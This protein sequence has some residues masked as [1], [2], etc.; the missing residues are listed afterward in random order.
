MPHDMPEMTQQFR[1]AELEVAK[2]VTDQKIV[3]IFRYETPGRTSGSPSL[4]LIAEIHS[5]LYAYERLL[6]VLNATAD[7][8]RLLVAQSDQDP[9]GRFEKLVQRLNEAVAN[10]NAQEPTQINWSRISVF[11]IELSDGHLC[12]TGTGQLMN[13]FLQ[14]Q[15]DGSFKGFDLFGSLEQPS[16]TD[17]QKPFGSIICGDI[18]PGDILFVGTTNLERLRN[19]LRMKERLT[20]LPPVTAALELR[21]DIERRG[22][23]DDFIGAVISCLEI[24]QPAAE[25]PMAAHADMPVSRS[26]DS[27]EKLRT[28]ER[29]AEE[30]LSPAIAPIGKIPQSKDIMDL[31]RVTGSKTFHAVRRTV[32][33]L[34]KKTNRDAVALASLRGM[35]AGYGTTFT[36]KKKLILSCIGGAIVLVIAGSLWWSHSKK[37]AAQNAA[38]NATFDSAADLRNRAE[39]DLV[40]GNEARARTEMT[41]AEQALTGLPTDT[42]DRQLKMQKIMKDISDLHER[43]KKVVAVDGVAELYALSVAAAPGSMSAPFI[44]KDAAYTV[45]QNAGE[46]VKVSLTT[47]EAKHIALPHGAGTL[48]SASAGKDSIFF[49]SQD[50]NLYALNTSSDLVKA[51][52]WSHSKASSTR[53]TVLYAN[54]LYSLDPSRNQIWRSVQSGSGFTGETPY[55]KASDASLEGAIGLAIDSNVYVL[56]SNGQLL[57]FLS[58]GQISLNLSSVDPAIRAASGIWTDADAA[59]IYVSDL[60]DKRVL[61]F[62]KNGS[63]KSQ[64][65]SPQFSQL[66]AISVDETN[67]RAVVIDNNRLLLVPLP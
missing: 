16:Q 8:A 61:V 46:I 21:Q 36:K 34:A 2:S 20:T 23:P 4:L 59:S 15:E 42:P 18:K 60:A 29:E 9:L 40:Y 7:Q 63:L 65:T 37:I 53:D 17:P 44:N 1:I 31:V 38:W 19:E 51:V 14:K 54:K 22:I 12:F 30:R 11:L 58:G 52:T 56:K 35:N 33:S 24:K 39:S 13:L 10:F 27:V 28:T 45:D 57:S 50:G 43:L 41:S 55:I 25:A 3:G 67:K 6:D 26:T 66:R 32:A 48:V 47:K 62:D 49:A 5:T 64:L